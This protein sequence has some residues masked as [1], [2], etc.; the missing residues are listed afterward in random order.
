[1]FKEVKRMAEEVGRP[2]VM[3]EDVIRKLEYA[4]MRGLSDREACLYANIA[5]STLYN[6]CNDNPA[7]SER[8]ELL[9]EQVK[10]KAK[11]IV[12]DLIDNNDADTAKWYL[13]RKAK[14]EFSTKQEI[15]AD[16]E[17]DVTITIELS[18]DE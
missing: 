1:V 4:Y 7:F 3:T 8:K 12:A 11:M 10:T 17:T 14:D 18:D 2:T 16:V 9:K 5:T 13:E 15:K 6:Y